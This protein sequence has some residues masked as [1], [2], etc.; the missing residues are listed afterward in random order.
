MC[1]ILGGPDALEIYGRKTRRLVE[2]RGAGS[3]KQNL[4]QGQKDEV[5]VSQLIVIFIAI[6]I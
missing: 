2:G 3:L 1:L 5:H 6:I 4:Q